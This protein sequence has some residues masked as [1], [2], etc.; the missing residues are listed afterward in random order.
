MVKQF[1]MVGVGAGCG[2]LN[3]KPGSTYKT[4]NAVGYAQE[5]YFPH[6]TGSTGWGG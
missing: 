3:L 2:L 5:Q 4:H 6:L 1:I